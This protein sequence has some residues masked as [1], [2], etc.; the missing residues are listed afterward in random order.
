MRESNRDVPTTTEQNV[1]W[2]KQA[3]DPHFF[4]AMQDEPGSLGLLERELGTLAAN[5]HLILADRPRAFMLATAKEPGSLYETMNLRKV[6]DRE[7]SYAMF[8]HSTETMPGMSRT[9]EIQRFE[10]DRKPHAE[11][12]AGKGVAMPPTCG[13]PSRWPCASC[14][15][16]ST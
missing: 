6:R 16:T 11:I 12:A 1:R 13:A 3:M 4:T 14:T 9:L 8:A 15:R 2:L 7:I 5:R 10:F